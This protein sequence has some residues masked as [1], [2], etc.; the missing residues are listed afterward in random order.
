VTLD[1]A[2]H[3]ADGAA[4]EPELVGLINLDQGRRPSV[5]SVVA[6]ILVV[7]DP[8]A[9]DRTW[10]R[11]DSDLDNR[12]LATFLLFI[13][14]GGLILA[15]RSAR[16]ALLPVLETLKWK[17]LTIF[18]LY[19]A[20]LAGSLIVAWKVGLFSGK[21]WAA[22]V[23]WFLI[24]GIGMFGRFVDV[25]VK[26]GVLSRQVVE[27]VGIVAAF[28]FIV[29]LQP[30]SI[31]IELPLQLVII[32]L[33]MIEAVSSFKPE[34]RP[35]GCAS[36]GLLGLITAV[37]VLHTIWR[38][39]ANRNSL[40]GEALLQLLILP[41]WLTVW[42]TPAVFLLGLVS[43]YEKQFLRLKWFNDRN[44]PK[45]LVLLAV[46]RGL[47]VVPSAVSGF[48]APYAQ[49]AARSG[50]YKETLRQIDQWKRDSQRRATEI[51]LNH[52][53]LD[54]YAGDQGTDASGRR[55]D[56]REF[57]E[58]KAALRFL[59]ACQSG[60]YGR[61]EGR[62]NRYRPD[63]LTVVSNFDLQG[64]PGEHGIKLCTRRDGRAWYA[65]RETVTGWVFAIGGVGSPPSEW[66]Y[67]GPTP[68][69]GFPSNAAGWTSSLEPE[70]PEWRSEPI[71]E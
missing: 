9:R 4:G 37:I 44:R 7:E 33:A 61:S 21:V 12:E 10:R 18:A 30:F 5:L 43:A 27:A 56:R 13:C 29:N 41:I 39:F 1:S 25:G 16:L 69:R 62:L 36:R 38:L 34:F 53:R 50:S 28:E 47:G 32:F 31:W 54:R 46:I 35:V 70:R 6:V 2:V 51:A 11:G 71:L 17:L 22:A 55:N 19:C 48:V 23:L 59:S 49:V 15:Y 68:P 60:W 67:D 26:K 42:A 24:A 14:A 40:D 3:V 58:T 52:W 65:W 57:R 8:C 63:I 64:L 45:L 66:Y 20:W